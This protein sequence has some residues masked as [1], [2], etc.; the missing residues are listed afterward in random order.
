MLGASVLL[1]L[2]QNRLA[3]RERERQREPKATAGLIH[4]AP[5]GT[6]NSDTHSSLSPTLHHEHSSKLTPPD[7]IPPVFMIPLMHEETWLA[8][9][10]I[11]N[12]KRE[13]N[14]KT[15]RGC[16]SCSLTTE[17]W[18]CVSMGRAEMEKKAPQKVI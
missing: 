11:I 12:V 1:F 3:I 10:R 2:S 15:L 8:F 7:E 9:M 6:L 17:N 5:R 13:S 18:T 14:N 16:Q 4:P